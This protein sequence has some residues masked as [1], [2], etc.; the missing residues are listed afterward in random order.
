[1][2]DLWRSHLDFDMRCIDQWLFMMI[3]AAAP[4]PAVT[5]IDATLAIQPCMAVIEC[6]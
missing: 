4:E 2:I 5:G 3:V 6:H 1:M